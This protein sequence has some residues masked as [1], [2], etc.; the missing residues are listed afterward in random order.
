[1]KTQFKFW[2]AGL[3]I[4]VSSFGT[5]AQ[6]SKIGYVNT[7]RIISES[8]PAKFASAKLEQE[9]SKRQKDITDL[10]TSLK[11]FGEKFERDAPTLADSQRSI[12]QKEYAELG[13]DIQ[14]KQRELQEDLNSR[15]N[16]ELIQVLDKAKKAVKTV[17]EL[18]KF[19]LILANEGS[20]IIAYSNSKL[21]I[22]DKVLKILNSGR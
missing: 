19:D 9:F 12:R 21:D 8:S 3:L 20:E 18:E 13:R 16:E 7:Q 11:S 2:G 4:A 22:T 14:R 5:F 6:E 1:M 10:Q 17:A 15:R